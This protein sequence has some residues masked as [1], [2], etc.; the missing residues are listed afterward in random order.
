M[1]E[2]MLV[3]QPSIGDAILS[4][5]DREH[6]ESTARRSGMVTLWE[7]ARVFVEQGI[8]SP[9]EIRRVLGL[10]SRGT[11]FDDVPPEAPRP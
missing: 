8:T 2:F 6:L 4:R 7:R 9:A 1:A 11:V 3:E 10:T 5:A